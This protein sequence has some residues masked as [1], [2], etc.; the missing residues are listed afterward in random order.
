MEQSVGLTIDL[1]IRLKDDGFQTLIL[2][3][4]AGFYVPSKQG[5]ED[6][7]DAISVIPLAEDQLIPISD[8]IQFFY[9]LDLAESKIKLE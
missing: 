8:A 3:H 6:L 5:I 9:E 2:R 4:K 1:L 7:S